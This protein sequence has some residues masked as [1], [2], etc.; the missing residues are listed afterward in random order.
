[1]KICEGCHATSVGFKL[2]M[3]FSTGRLPCF[4]FFFVLKIDGALPMF[5][6]SEEV[7][8]IKKFEKH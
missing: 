2:Y 5:E 6:G 1:M 7:R 4:V 3:K 8:Q